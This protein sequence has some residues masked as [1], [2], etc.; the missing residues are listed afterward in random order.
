[1]E[2][3][4][5]KLVQGKLIVELSN[6]ILSNGINPNEYPLYEAVI[7]ETVNELFSETPDKLQLP[8]E[9]LNIYLLNQWKENILLLLR[10]TNSTVIFRGVKLSDYSKLKEQIAVEFEKLVP[11]LFFK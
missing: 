10:N 8:S 6:L 5:H 1:M 11:N 9:E 7:F 3:T 4:N 2:K